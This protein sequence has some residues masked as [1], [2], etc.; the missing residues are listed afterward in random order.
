MSINLM[1]SVVKI[2]ESKIPDIYLINMSCGETSIQMD[3]HRSVNIVKEGDLVEVVIDKK[4]PTYIE[5]R[6][7]VAHGYVV[8]KREVGG[9]TRIHVSLWGYLVVINT[10]SRAVVEFFNYM[11]KVYIRMSRSPSPYPKT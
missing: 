6:D 2:D 1:C 3:I 11:D 10:S 7:F 8:S 4:V 5:G 9:S